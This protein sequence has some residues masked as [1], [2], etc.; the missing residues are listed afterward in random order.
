MSAFELKVDD[1]LCKKKMAWMKY[2]EK[3]FDSLQNRGYLQNKVY[4][5]TEKML[6]EYINHTNDDKITKKFT[7]FII[8]E[9]GQKAFEE[10]MRYS[11]ETL[12][13]IEQKPNV[14]IFEIIKQIIEIMKTDNLDYKTVPSYINWIFHSYNSYKIEIELYSDLWNAAYLREVIERISFDCYRIVT[15]N[16]VSKMVQNL[17]TKIIGLDKESSLKENSEINEKIQLLNETKTK[18]EQF[19][20]IE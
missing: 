8:K 13:N 16:L 5:I 15:V 17:L 9:I 6:I 7:S 11:I 1:P 3:Y 14:K 18:F 20:N 10:K 4:E 12:I 19:L 2:L